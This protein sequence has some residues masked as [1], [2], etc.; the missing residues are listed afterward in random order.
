M[1]GVSY[2]KSSGLFVM[3]VKTYKNSTLL[4]AI[5]IFISF[6][7]VLLLFVTNSPKSLTVFGASVDYPVQMVNISN[8]SGNIGL[9]DT[10]DISSL[11][12]TTSTSNWENW[13]IRYVGNDSKGSYYKIVNMESG[14]LL[15][16]MKYNTSSGS[17][18]VIYG[19][20]S[21]KSQHWYIT[22]VSQDSLGNDLY[23][24]ITN[25]VDTN[26]SLTYDGSKFYLSEYTGNS[27]Q[28]W[29]LNTSGVQGF[30]GYGT[31]M[32]GN[33]KASV[34]GGL[35]GDTVYVSTYDELKTA[36]KSSEPLTIVITKD[37]SYSTSY[38]TDSNG[39]KYID[40]NELIYIYPNKTI[41]GSYGANS[42][43]NVYFRTYEHANYGLGKDIILRNVEISHD[44][45]LNISNICEF[46]YGE[47]IWVD[48]CTFVGH[49][50][51]NSASTGIVDWDKLLAFKGNTDYCTI[52]DCSFGLHEYG[53]ILGYPD[54]TDELLD[55]YNNRPCITL[56]D[57]YFH[58]CLTRAPGLMRYGYYHSLNNY[59]VNFNMG[60]TVHTASTV[61]AESCYYDGGTGKGAVV[62]DN[63]FKSGE[64]SI[65]E[66][67]RDEAT[68]SY[69][70][71]GSVAVNCYSNNNVS[72]IYSNV[73]TWNPSSNY[74][75]TSMSASEV[76]NYCKT[77]AGAKSS[78]SEYSY[79]TFGSTGLAS[80]N[81]GVAP[82]TT[83]NDATT[84]VTTVTTTPVTSTIKEASTI[85][86]NKTFT[87]KNVNSGLYMEVE[88]GT[89]A[90]GTNVQQWGLSTPS[91]YNTWTVKSAGDG[92]YYIYSSLGDG[93]T[94]LLDLDR[95][96]T[97]NGANISIYEN[98]NSDAQL[99]KFVKNSDGSYKI[100]TKATQDSSCVEV[101]DASTS[102]GA[103]VQQW[104]INGVNCQD[105]ILEYVEIT[106]DTTTTTTTP[107]T[108]TT[109]VTTTA[110]TTGTVTVTTPYD[111]FKTVSLTGEI[112]KIY[113]NSDF[114]ITQDDGSTTYI[115]NN[116][117]SAF[118][119]TIDISEFKV[120]DKVDI[121]GLSLSTGSVALTSIKLSDG[122]VTTTAVTTV[123]TEPTVTTTTGNSSDK[124]VFGDI[125]KDG[126]ASYLDIV[127][128]KKYILGMSSSIDTSRADLNKDGAINILD[129][130]IL[131][132]LV[133]G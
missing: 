70:D 56:A 105:W 118:T 130:I 98:T 124:N 66:S 108:T 7:M 107:T 126:N 128:L 97:T 123:P 69:K 120:G 117:S 17:E 9:V 10:A 35:L 5:T 33:E 41:V 37:I 1:K 102:S 121:S 109:T 84:T 19:D 96:L 92:Y 119:K 53:L 40:N 21:D 38:L 75:Y 55:T 78:R 22:A 68:P 86:E 82:T 60:Y 129:V 132:D 39:R 73:C 94:Y 127:I 25:Y 57:N 18:C 106:Q 32:D 122:A 3:N 74:S 93:K 133:I 28:K 81:F 30:A 31:D 58:D 77:N 14:R 13:A 44:V 103:N 91:T 34:H 67:R 110:T 11:K 48:H 72:N 85:T 62:N 15:T 52:S 89:Q 54:D 99:F 112:T 65:S 51:V 76:P 80:A 61:Y 43:Y 104:E 71:V 95:G 114:E 20:E 6:S 90:S 50:A 46:S 45:E 12:L 111:N 42:L 100:V 16:P 88:G 63:A 87:L 27:S 8:G 23:Y 29:L 131:K 113:D 125:D 26:L 101:K 116:Y 36:C 24:K 59:V 49:D 2:K 83:W 79:Y 47:N 4:K 115:N 64:T